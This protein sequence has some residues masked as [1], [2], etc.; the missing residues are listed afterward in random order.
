MKK[1]Q[2]KSKTLCKKK[3]KKRLQKKKIYKKEEFLDCAVI[4]QKDKK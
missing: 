3:I 1:C 2:K 4:K